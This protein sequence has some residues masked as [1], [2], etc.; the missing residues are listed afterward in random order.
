MTYVNKRFN[1]LFLRKKNN[2][3][4]LVK[5]QDMK[6]LPDSPPRRLKKISHDQKI[7]VHV[8]NRARL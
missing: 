6:Y 5:R 7:E 8:E 4:T 2:K 1:Q 3:N